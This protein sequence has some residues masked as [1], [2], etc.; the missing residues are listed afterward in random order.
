MVLFWYSQVNCTLC[1]RNRALFFNICTQFQILVI[2]EIFPCFLFM[3]LYES[4]LEIDQQT[5]H[6]V[7]VASN[8]G[9][10]LQILSLSCGEK[11]QDKIQNGKPRFEADQS[12]TECHS[13]NIK[14]VNMFRYCTAY[15]YIDTVGE[16]T[17]PLPWSFYPRRSYYHKTWISFSVSLVPLLHSSNLEEAEGVQ[18]LHGL[19]SP[20]APSLSENEFNTHYISFVPRPF[21]GKTNH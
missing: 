6:Y 8:S 1:G 9:F 4:L 15:I 16:F 11:L 12:N 3:C 2:I 13:G 20:Q 5:H 18:Y 17:L 19:Q 7:H 21:V 10:P 14:H